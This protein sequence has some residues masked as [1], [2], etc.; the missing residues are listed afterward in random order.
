MSE[1]HEQNDDMNNPLPTDEIT[2]EELENVSGGFDP[3]P[4]PPSQGTSRGVFYLRNA[5]T[6]L[7][8]PDLDSKGSI[9]G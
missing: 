5:N 7:Q 2:D 1:Q 8:P 6:P 9:S 3:Q 4:D